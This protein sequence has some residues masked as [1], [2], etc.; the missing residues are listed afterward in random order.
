MIKSRRMRCVERVTRMG[1][2]E[3]EIAFRIMVGEPEIKTG[4]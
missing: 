1:R 3:R 4:V 2:G